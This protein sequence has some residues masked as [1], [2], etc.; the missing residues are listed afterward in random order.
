M[1]H[2]LKIGFYWLKSL[3]SRVAYEKDE[4]VQFLGE[5]KLPGL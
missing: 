1:K 2:T 5:V 3:L 4:E